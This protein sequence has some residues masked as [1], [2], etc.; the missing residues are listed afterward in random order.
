MSHFVFNNNYCRLIPLHNDAYVRHPIPVAARPLGIWPSNEF[1]GRVNILGMDILYE[2]I[3]SSP[4]G[5][6]ASV[7]E[8][9]ADDF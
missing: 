5:R 7:L 8:I 9:S 4:I 3:V 2:T 6:H 1:P